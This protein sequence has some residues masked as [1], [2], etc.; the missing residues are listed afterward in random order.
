MIA[1]KKKVEINAKSILERVTPYDIYRYYIGEDFTLG[2]VMQSPMPGRRDSNPSFLVGARYGFLYHIDFADSRFRGNCFQFVMQKEMVGYNDALRKINK[3]FSLALGIEGGEVTG[4]KPVFVQPEIKDTQPTFIQVQH[5][6][7]F[8]L[9]E[10]EYWRQYYITPQECEENEIYA[11]RNFLINRQKQPMRRGELI[12][13]YK[14]GSLWKIYRPYACKDRKWKNNIPIDTIENL[15][16]LTDC[17]K[18]II[19]KARKDRVVLQ[20]FL[21]QVASVQNESLV[22]LN[23]KSVDFLHKNCNEVYINYDADEPGK[24]NSWQVTSEFGFKHL[25]V[26]DFYLEEGIK[27]FADLIKVYGPDKVYDYLK[28]KNIL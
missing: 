21:P 15:R 6:S 5:T 26:P 2:K 13:G 22:A 18:G 1:G 8:T 10:K 24:R 11:V 27:D 19:T 7:K 16:A 23:V 25:N 17:E 9:E 14:L 20:K 28:L 4:V 12:F 3:D